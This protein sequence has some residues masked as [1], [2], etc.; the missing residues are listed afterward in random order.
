[1]LVGSPKGNSPIGREKLTQPICVYTL[2]PCMHEKGSLKQAQSVWLCTSSWEIPLDL[3]CISQ[4]E[5]H[6][7]SWGTMQRIE[8]IQESL[9][10]KSQCEFYWWRCVQKGKTARCVLIHPVNSPWLSPSSYLKSRTKISTFF[11]YFL[12]K[13]SW[14]WILSV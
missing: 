3:H 5:V 11:Y 1:M 7:H 10:S 6:S 12:W 14:I 8:K 2:L 13:F 4:L 9:N